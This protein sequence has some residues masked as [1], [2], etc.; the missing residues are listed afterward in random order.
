MI[1][2]NDNNDDD[3]VSN[4]SNELG[5]LYNDDNDSIDDI[6]DVIEDDDVKELREQFRIPRAITLKFDYYTRVID[7]DTS[8]KELKL[9]LVKKHHSLW[10]EYVYNASRVL[11]DYIDTQKINCINKSVLELGAAAGLPGIIASLNGAETVIITDY[12]TDSEKD[13]IYAIDINIAS[14][15]QYITKATTVVGMDYIWGY[16]CD[17]FISFNSGKLFDIVIMA[18]LIFNR[19]EHR[20]LLKTL[21][22]TL[23]QNGECWCCFSHHDPHKRELDLAFFTIAEEEFGFIVSKEGQEQRQSYPFVE[24]DGR[25][26][27]RGVVYIY[28]IVAR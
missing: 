5:L 27:E 28:K 13:L 21:K 12:G 24:D 25:D 16:S 20:K 2:S 8:P 10:A 6:D 7:T 23:S 15:K 19:S 26:N 1:S 9:A 22:M 3:N 18:D 4:E 14:I 11:A 17:K